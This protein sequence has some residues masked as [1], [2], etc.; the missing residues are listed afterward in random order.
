MFVLPI[1]II[2]SSKLLGE[3]SDFL[4]IFDQVKLFPKPYMVSSIKIYVIPNIFYF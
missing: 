4:G 3:P 2:N 1:L